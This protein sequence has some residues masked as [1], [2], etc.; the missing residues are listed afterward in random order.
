MYRYLIFHSGRLTSASMSFTLHTEPDVSPPEFTLTCRSEG[1]PATTVLWQRYVTTVGGDFDHET[2]QVI[3]DLSA[4]TVYENRLRVRRR[5][6]GSYWCIVR[7]DFGDDS[8]A[9]TR[10]L[11]LGKW[12]LNVF[13]VA[14]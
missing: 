8:Q 11:I 7:N 4:N 5:E 1:G 12:N 6:G 13:T 9:D 2:S 3:V 10:L 14:S